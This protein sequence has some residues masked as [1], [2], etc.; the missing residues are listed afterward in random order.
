MDF[1]N[2]VDLIAPYAALAQGIGRIGCF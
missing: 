1:W 2:V